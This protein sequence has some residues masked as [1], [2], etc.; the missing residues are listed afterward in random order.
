[1]LQVLLSFAG[2]PSR[3]SLAVFAQGWIKNAVKALEH[4]YTTALMQ[5]QGLPAQ[6]GALCA[7]LDPMLDGLLA[8]NA[9]TAS[10]SGGTA[11]WL[12]QGSILAA[13][14]LQ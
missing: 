8:H 6:L 7:C 4:Q 3:G 11:P 13:G 14:T 1:M 9:R 5:L 2:I 12:K 10:V